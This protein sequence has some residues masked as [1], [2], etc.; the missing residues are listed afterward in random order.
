MGLHLR[1]GN[2]A[3]FRRNREISFIQ[4]GLVLISSNLCVTKG[5]VVPQWSLEPFRNKNFNFNFCWSIGL[6]QFFKPLG[7]IDVQVRN[8]KGQE[9]F[10]CLD[11]TSMGSVAF[12]KSA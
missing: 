5:L 7:I 8:A 1:E 4:Q 3:V 12:L 11:I 6:E 10:Q 2:R 9:V